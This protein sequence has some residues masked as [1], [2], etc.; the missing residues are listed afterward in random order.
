MSEPIRPQHNV[1]R[2]TGSAYRIAK[3]NA[4]AGHYPRAFLAFG[5][6]AQGSVFMEECLI[7][8][9]D[10]NE[11]VDNRLVREIKL[12]EPAVSPAN[13]ITSAEANIMVQDGMAT[14]TV[15]TLVEIIN[16]RKLQLHFLN[17]MQSQGIRPKAYAQ[18]EALTSHDYL[19]Y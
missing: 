15:E 9:G 7:V 10:V 16:N 8:R 3:T 14:M 18:I 4:G 13:A 19:S 12:M 6:D 1:V 17:A 2:V 11:T 5:S